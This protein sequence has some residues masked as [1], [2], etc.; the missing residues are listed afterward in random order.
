V[1]RFWI[2]IDHCCSAAV[3]ETTQ[4]SSIINFINYWRTELFFSF[5]PV[6]VCPPSACLFLIQNK[7]KIH[8][9]T[10]WRTSWCR[11]ISENALPNYVRE[12]WSDSNQWSQVVAKFN[13]PH[14]IFTIELMCGA[15][16]SQIKHKPNLVLSVRLHINCMHMW[17]NRTVVL[18]M[19]ILSIYGFQNNNNYEYLALENNISMII[20]DAI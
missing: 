19:Y 8:A 18:H 3:S 5:W 1:K 10:P 7:K 17:W 20:I 14:T 11:S 9:Y 2:I 16:V 12:F 6:N 15:I 4:I 13:G